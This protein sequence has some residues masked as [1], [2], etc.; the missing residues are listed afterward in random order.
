MKWLGFENH[1]FKF[2]GGV[3]IQSPFL[4]GKHGLSLF[5][6]SL[7][8]IFTHSFIQSFIRSTSNDDPLLWAISVVFFSDD[9]KQHISIA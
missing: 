4:K 7:D 9:E 5:H 6:L 8:L 2:K 1:F 3:T